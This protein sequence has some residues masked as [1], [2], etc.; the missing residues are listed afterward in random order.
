MLISLSKDK[1]LA[2]LLH[3]DEY[4]I[5]LYSSIPALLYKFDISLEQFITET[6][7]RYFAAVKCPLFYTTVDKYIQTTFDE[8]VTARTFKVTN[9]PYIIPIIEYSEYLKQ[10]NLLYSKLKQRLTDFH[11]Y[12]ADNE[13]T[14]SLDFIDV[15]DS[16]NSSYNE[17]VIL[18]NCVELGRIINIRQLD[19]NTPREFQSKSF[20]IIIG[21][22]ANIL[23]NDSYRTANN[24]SNHIHLLYVLDFLYKELLLSISL[25]SPQVSELLYAIGIYLVNELQKELIYYE[26]Y[27]ANT[28]IEEK[29]ISFRFQSYVFRNV[30]EELNEKIPLLTYTVLYKLLEN[31]S[32]NIFRASSFMKKVVYQYLTKYLDINTFKYAFE[33]TNAPEY[34]NTLTDLI[35]E[36]LRA[37]LEYLC[38]TEIETELDYIITNQMIY[39]NALSPN[40]IYNKWKG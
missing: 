13:I 3:E 30:I 6:F 36:I 4:D 7:F 22:T 2:N 35:I 23:S 31:N 18:D 32:I 17:P 25:T 19:N 15:V 1:H 20:P 5:S 24:I 28:N 16:E 21:F 27:I 12:I 33:L 10:I 9:V 8:S 38:D 39:D 14:Y 29:N 37:R 40:M 26:T 34:D 11:N